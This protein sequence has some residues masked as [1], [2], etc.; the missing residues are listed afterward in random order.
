MYEGYE[1]YHHLND[2]IVLY[3]TLHS[4]LM[5][6][7][8]CSMHTQWNMHQNRLHAGYKIS[9]KEFKSVKIIHTIFFTS[10]YKII[11]SEINDIFGISSVQFSHSI[12]SDSLRPHESQHTKPPCPSPTPRVHSDSCPSSQ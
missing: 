12:V 5:E 6:K 10:D 3:K 7:T 11:K 8:V 9:M 1:Q 2:M 4:V